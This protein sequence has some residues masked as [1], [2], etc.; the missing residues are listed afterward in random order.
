MSYA[1]VNYEKE[2]TMMVVNRPDISSIERLENELHAEFLNMSLYG[3]DNVVLQFKQFINLSNTD[4]LNKLAIAMRKDL[5][6]INT[7]L[8]PDALMLNS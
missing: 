7:K 1:L 8:R 5:Y 2:K 3:S 6:G 4:T